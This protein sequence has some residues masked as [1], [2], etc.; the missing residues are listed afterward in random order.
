MANRQ[1]YIANPLEV[2]AARRKIEKEDA[3]K[4]AMLVLV[5]LDAAKRG[6]APASLANTLTEQ[7]LTSAAVWSMKGNAALY[8][9]SVKAWNAL[10]KA[11]A[12]PTVLLDLTTGEYAAIRVAIANYVKALPLLDAGTLATAHDKA[13]RQL[14]S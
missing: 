3:D 13:I 10:L 11:C 4:I 8:K 2:L 6:A 7:L 12:R 5:A 14:R 1:T 9:T